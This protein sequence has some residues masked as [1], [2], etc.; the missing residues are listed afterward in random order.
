VQERTPT[1]ACRN[2]GA[3]DPCIWRQC[4]RRAE[5]AQAPECI[6][7]REEHDKKTNLTN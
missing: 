6:K 4:N 2:A 1:E 3:L 5:F 7:L